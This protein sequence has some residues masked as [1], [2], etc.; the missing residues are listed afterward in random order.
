MDDIG[1][2]VLFIATKFQEIYPPTLEVQSLQFSSNPDVI[3]ELEAQILAVL[4]YNI[5]P[6]IELSIVGILKAEL[7]FKVEFIGLKI[8][9]LVRSG[10]MTGHLRESN[11]ISTIFG[12][13]LAQTRYVCSSLNSKAERVC[14]KYGVDVQR[15]RVDFI[16]FYN[17]RMAY[18]SKFPEFFQLLSN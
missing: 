8:D 15:A 2:T 10:V 12:L 16:A 18:K 14:A 5:Q 4:D 9:E 17:L 11:I 13:V 7:D 1:N 6:S 3:L